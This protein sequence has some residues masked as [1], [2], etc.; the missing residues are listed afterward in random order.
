[1]HSNGSRLCVENCKL[2]SGRLLFGD[3]QQSRMCVDQCASTPVSTFGYNNTGL[4]V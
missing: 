3:V 2:E 4:C 1:M